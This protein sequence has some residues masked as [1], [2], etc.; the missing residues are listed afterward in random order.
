MQAV[1]ADLQRGGWLGR[2]ST[3][4]QQIYR[5]WLIDQIVVLVR[6]VA[7]AS[8]LLW[9]VVAPAGWLFLPGGPPQSLW[10][11]SYGVVLPTLIAGLGTTFTRLRR[12][13]VPIASVTLVVITA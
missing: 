1:S 11:I 9:M 10:V 12:W 5:H 13:V 7:G 2:F 8:I 4:V 6:Y 3:V